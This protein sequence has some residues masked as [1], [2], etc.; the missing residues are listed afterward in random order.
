MDFVVDNFISQFLTEQFMFRV[1]SLLQ[2]T[3]SSQKYY[4]K[5]HTQLLDLILRILPVENYNTEL[6]DNFKKL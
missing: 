2:L 5:A 6:S 4:A 1:L 3:N